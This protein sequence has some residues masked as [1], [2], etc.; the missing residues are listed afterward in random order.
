MS[1]DATPVS[2]TEVEQIVRR[3][4]VEFR[5]DVHGIN[6]NLMS[7]ESYL[8]A[9]VNNPDIK[10]AMDTG[11]VTD[12]ETEL[13]DPSLTDWQHRCVVTCPELALAILKDEPAALHRPF[14]E[15]ALLRRLLTFYV[16][17]GT[18]GARWEAAAQVRQIMERHF[19]LQLVATEALIDRAA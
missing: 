19:S 3:K 1:I 11:L 8:Q 18:E 14:V 7:H 10:F 17:A 5:A 12:L 2:A 4:M 16:P 6:L 9:A 15:G 13:R